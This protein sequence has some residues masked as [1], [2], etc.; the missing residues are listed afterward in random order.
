MT[1][2]IA[3]VRLFYRCKN[4]VFASDSVLMVKLVFWL[5]A[6]KIQVCQV[7]DLQLNL[8]LRNMYSHFVP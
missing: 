4:V 1:M 5:K 7:Y 2:V 6:M 3:Q 8:N